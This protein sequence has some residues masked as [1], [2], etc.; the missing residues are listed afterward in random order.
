MRTKINKW[1][2]SLA[3][4]IPKSFALEARIEE[5]T[6]VDLVLTEGKIMMKPIRS[7]QLSLSALLE[8]VTPDNMHGEISTG[9]PRG[10][11]NW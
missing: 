6:T 11:E 4:R 9:I 2:N 7:K 8:G 3:L 1:G 5:G 10:K